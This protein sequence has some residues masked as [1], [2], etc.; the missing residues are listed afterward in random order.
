MKVIDHKTKGKAKKP[1]YPYVIRHLVSENHYLRIND[2]Q[3]VSLVDGGLYNVA[4]A[5]ERH[6]V[7]LDYGVT[8]EPIY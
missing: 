3:I 1:C 5:E 4:L 8:I 2:N 7:V 6:Y